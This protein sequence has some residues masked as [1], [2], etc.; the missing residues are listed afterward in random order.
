MCTCR[1]PIV[2]H[3]DLELLLTIAPGRVG[4]ALLHTAEDEL[5]RLPFE[6]LLAAL[7]SK[8]FPAFSRPPEYLIRAALSIRVSRRLV[9]YKVAFALDQ[10]AAPPLINPSV[11]H[12]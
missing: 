12:I 9:A 1:L 6:Q 3:Q 11:W 7:N 2:L 4:L 8:R 10:G 5:C